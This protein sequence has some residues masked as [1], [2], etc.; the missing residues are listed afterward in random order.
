MVYVS[1]H[2]NNRGTRLQIL[3]LVGFFDDGLCHFGTDVFR[4]ETEFFGHEVD[5]FCVQAL[6]DGHHDTHAHAGGDDLRHGYVH[7]AGQFVGGHEFR[8]FQHFAFGFLQVL[9]FLTAF[10]VLFT[11]FLAVFGCLVL[12]LGGEAGQ[13]LF[14]LLGH[15]FFAHFLLDDGLL[16]AVLVLL[17]AALGFLAASAFRMVTA[18]AFREVGDVVDVYLFLIDAGTLLFG[19]TVFGF[20]AALGIVAAYFLDDGLLHLFALVLALF[21]LFF[22]FTAFFLL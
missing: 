15:V 18:S 20:L 22:A 2:R 12:A 1:H 19:V 8:Q 21:F 3:F 10:G 14:H 5:G 11:F 4:F 9:Q 6:V 7:H 16:E 13:R 17:S